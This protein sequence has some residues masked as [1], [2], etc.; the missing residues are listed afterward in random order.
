MKKYYK[1]S[2][3]FTAIKFDGE[4][5]KEVVEFLSGTHYFLVTRHHVDGNTCQVEKHSK[6]LFNI[7]AGQLII[8]D[9]DDTVGW[10][11]N[12]EPLRGSWVEIRDEPTL[13][14]EY[15]PRIVTHSAVYTN[16]GKASNNCVFVGGR[17]D[18]KFHELHRLDCIHP[19]N[20]QIY[21]RTGDMEFTYSHD[22]EENPDV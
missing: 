20:E 1:K 14:G 12:S 3:T 7:C 21:F 6:A 11:K 18:G 17:H 2:D 5:I 8:R 15:V 13:V 16:K 19:C 4:N 22:V 10:Q 9:S